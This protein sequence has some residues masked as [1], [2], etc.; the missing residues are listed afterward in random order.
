MIQHTF[1]LFL[2]SEFGTRIK[3]RR[4]IFPWYSWGSPGRPPWSSLWQNH[5]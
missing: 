3:A 2:K 4:E 5:S 1:P